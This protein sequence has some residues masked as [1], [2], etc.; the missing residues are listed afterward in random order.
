MKQIKIYLSFLLVLVIF[1]GCQKEEITSFQA[2]GAVNFDRMANLYNVQYSFLTNPANEY[3]Q[4]IPV[5]I[6]GNPVDQDRTFKV[7]VVRDSLTT[8]TDDQFEIV[9]GTVKAGEFN[10]KLTIRLLKSPVLD[11]SMVSLKLKLV[12]S[13]DFKAGNVEAREFV[14][15][16]TNKVIVPVWN[17][18]LRL[19]ITPKG[20]TAAF[21]LFMQISGLTQFLAKDYVALGAAGTEALGT[22][23]GDYIMQWNKD[24][25]DNIMRHDDGPAAGQPIVPVYYTR[26]KF[27]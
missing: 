24:N 4:E 15:S 23:Y 20:S 3:L 6:I 7:E 18:Y 21:R 2:P 12:D 25:P 16:W 19:F 26:S 8:A 22:R 10:G 13:E 5:Q 9:G 17:V 14:V 11:N 1:S 27:D